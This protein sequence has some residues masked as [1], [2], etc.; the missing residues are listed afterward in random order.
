MIY[1]THTYSRILEGNSRCIREIAGLRDVVSWHG[2]KHGCE[3]IG[4]VKLDSLFHQRML[5]KLARPAWTCMR[6]WFKGYRRG[7]RLMFRVP[8]P[9][10]VLEMQAIQ[11]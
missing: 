3:D 8:S 11:A 4:D 5:F 10:E 2:N 7:L 1:K 9:K 6:E